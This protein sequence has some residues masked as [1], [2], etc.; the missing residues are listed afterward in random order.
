[1]RGKASRERLRGRRLEMHSICLPSGAGKGLDGSTRESATRAYVRA[2][3]IEAEARARGF[4]R[5]PALAAQPLFRCH[6]ATLC[7]RARFAT[8]TIK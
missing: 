3:K 2:G 4:G 8:I 1:M 5:S 7:W 6:A